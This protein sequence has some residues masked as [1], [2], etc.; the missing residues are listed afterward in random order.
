MN[1]ECTDLVRKQNVPEAY[2]ELKR[3]EKGQR[4]WRIT[5]G[6]IVESWKATITDEIQC[7][8]AIKPDPLS[9]RGP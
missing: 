9:P 8:R 3:V 7:P 6:S 2:R 5:D 4:P 1:T